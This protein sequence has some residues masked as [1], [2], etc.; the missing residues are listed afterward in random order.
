MERER[1]G[2]Q[3]VWTRGTQ[4]IWI[5]NYP[6]IYKYG[7]P[8]ISRRPWLA[9]G[10]GEWMRWCGPLQMDFYSLEGD[11]FRRGQ[12]CPIYT[13]D[14]KKRAINQSDR[15]GVMNHPPNL[16]PGLI[17][18]SLL[19]GDKHNTHTHTHKKKKEWMPTPLPLLPFST[20]LFLSFLVPIAHPFFC[21]CCV[22]ALLISFI[23]CPY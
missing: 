10:R 8:T 22:F 23:S 15:A 14:I 2:L 17:T 3:D 7:D 21:S 6:S 5:D 20:F 9:R 4:K 16:P 18:K 19:S 1:F 13:A 12:G 11:Q